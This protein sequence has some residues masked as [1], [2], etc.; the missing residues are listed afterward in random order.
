MSSAATQAGE[1]QPLNPRPDQD[2]N[3]LAYRDGT[4]TWR[5]RSL[6]S[7]KEIPPYGHEKRFMPHFATCRGRP[8]LQIVPDNVTPLRRRRR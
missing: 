4:G 1:R 5:A 7:T 8:Q 2:G 6:A 3:V